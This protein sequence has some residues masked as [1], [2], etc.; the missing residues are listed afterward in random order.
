MP[1]ASKVVLH[2]RVILDHTIVGQELTGLE[3][4][5]D[6]EH[7]ACRLC[8][9][10]FQAARATYSLNYLYTP[11]VQQ[12]VAVET[13]LWRNRHNKLHPDWQHV[14]FK[15]SGRTFTPEASYRLASYGIVPVGDSNDGEIAAALWEAPRLPTNEPERF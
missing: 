15:K 12:E 11:L 2:T 5:K 9:A 1:V 7:A 14:Q 13:Q 10:V 8:G 4:R 6:R 3:F